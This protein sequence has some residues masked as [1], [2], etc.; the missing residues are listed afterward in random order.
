[1]V[2]QTRIKRRQCHTCG[3]EFDVDL[4]VTGVGRIMFDAMTRNCTDCRAK[5]AEEMDRL[6]ETSRVDKINKAS[7]NFI[8]QAHM[9]R[10]L[11]EKTFKVWKGRSTA[12][13]A[14]KEFAE[15]L[16][17]SATWGYR[18]M[19]LYSKMNGLGKSHLAAATAN[20]IFDRWR[21]LA[22]AG[23]ID[24]TEGNIACPVLYHTGPD[25]LVRVRSTYNIR[26][27]EAPWRETEAD[28]YEKLKNVKL[29]ILDDIG[30]EGERVASEHTQRVYFQIIDGRYL[31]QLPLLICS[32]LDLEEMAAFLGPKVGPAV[33]DRL[34][35]MTGDRVIELRGQSYRKRMWE[36]GQDG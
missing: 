20:S 23:E 31:N 14:A 15:G 21:K 11:W 26:P 36:E 22:L 17:L 28:L 2:P 35:E 34:I 6:E 1:M 7:S 10:K 27:D 5:L 29:L 32:N 19:V 13:K 25:L 4:P 3:V 30:K 24:T 9:P 8:Y 12:Y 18:S 16:P 33:K